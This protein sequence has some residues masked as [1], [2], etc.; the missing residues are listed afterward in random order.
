MCQTELK[1]SKEVI[2]KTVKALLPQLNNHKGINTDGCLFQKDKWAQLALTKAPFVEKLTFSKTCDLEG[3]FQVKMDSF[4]P[5]KLKIKNF[6]NFT[7]IKSNIKLS[8]ILID[9]PILRIEMVRT[10]ISGKKELEF[11]LEY[12]VYIDLLSEHPMQKHKGGK[13]HLKRIGKKIINKSFPVLLN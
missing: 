7:G 4:F 12:E 6:K 11:S 10:V 3:K 9:K 8:I 2:I 13:F 5:L 1:N